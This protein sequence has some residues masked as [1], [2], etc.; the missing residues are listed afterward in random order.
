MYVLTDDNP[1]AI[2]DVRADATY[3]SCLLSIARPGV[4]EAAGA[5]KNDPRSTTLSVLA[6]G[7]SLD[8]ASH[9]ETNLQPKQGILRNVSP[10]PPPTVVSLVDLD[11]DVVLPLLQPTITSI[12][13]PEISNAAQEL[14]TQQQADEPQIEKLSLK[15]TPKSDHKSSAVV[16]LEKIET[17]LR[18]VQLALEILTGACA[19]LPDP[20]LGPTDDGE[21]DEDE[22]LDEGLYTLYHWS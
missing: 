18:T 9:H 22:V 19:T 8:P 5:D 20:E 7:T 12:S 2:A 4:N 10:L 1:P 15:H 17:Q 16:E 13:I 6:A 3:L 21:G 14:I 11:K